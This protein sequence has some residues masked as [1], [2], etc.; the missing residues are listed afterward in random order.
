MELHERDPFSLLVKPVRRLVEERGF[1]GATGPQSRAIPLI[2]DGK[3]VLLIAPTGTGKTEAAFLPVFS[4]L[5]ELV[6]KPLGIKVLYIT[7]LRS[8]NRDLLDRLKWWCQSLD[9]R[10]SVRHGDTEAKE[11]FQQSHNP[12]DILITTPETLQAILPGRILR[13]HLSHIRWVI[14][15]EV[16]EFAEDKR[17]SQLS[18]ALER[19]RLLTEHDFQ[20][21]GLSATIGNPERVAKFL[22]G[23]DR[24]VELVKVPVVR[25]TELQ[26]IYPIATEDD[27]EL[28]ENLYT[29]PEVASRLR[30]MRNIIEGQRAVLLFTNTRSAAEVLASRFKIWDVNFPVSIHHGSLAKPAR[31]TAEQGLKGGEL[32]GLVCTSSLELGIDIGNIDLC[33]QYMSPRQV[34]RLIQRVGR[35]GHSLGR[36]AK[37]VIITIDSDDT[38]EAMVI[39]R[40]AALET[41]EPAHIP[42]KPLDALTHQIVG[43]LIFQQRWD[44]S[45]IIELCNRA[46]PYRELSEEDLISVL[47][48]MHSRYPRLGWVSFENKVVMRPQSIKEMYQFYYENL[49]MIPDEKNYI[50]IDETKDMPVGVLDEAFVAE[51]GNPGTKF[52]VRGSPWKVSNV[53]GDK[54]YV[55]PIDDPTGAIPSWI[56]EEI[57]V[58]FEVAIEVG[59]IRKLVEESLDKGETLETVGD[60][61]AS[62]YSVD[63]DTAIRA[64]DETAKQFQ[65]GLSMP[66]D[67]RVTIEKWGEFIIIHASFGSLVNRSLAT[68][69]GYLLSEKVGSAVGVQEDPYRVVIQ[70]SETVTPIAIKELLS[71]LA[72][73]D[74]NSLAA[75]SLSNTGF[76]K[77]RMIH[78]ARKFGAISKMVDFSNISLNQLTK[79]FAGTAIYVEAM[80]DVLSKDL[81]L[82]NLR[83]VLDGFLKGEIEVV[84]VTT[85]GEAT[86]I[87]QVGLE[88]IKRQTNIVSSERMKRLTIDSVRIRLLGEVRTFVCAENW[89]HVKMMS[90]KDFLQVSVCPNCGS[91]KIGILNE[92]AKTVEKMVWKKHRSLTRRDKIM[93]DRALKTGEL[94]EK[95]GAVAAI[96]LVTRHLRLSEVEELISSEDELNDQLIDRIVE[97]E[98]KALARQFW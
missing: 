60:L 7:P 40:R 72:S 28:A 34:T 89:D 21:I 51:Y 52:I 82:E 30:I 69:L 29:R 98:R 24:P 36:V 6:E 1:V 18:L 56:G 54:I 84:T 43:L 26:I 95:H 81:D 53:Y 90:V 50:V 16:H 25:E 35:S 96:A 10:V 5:L 57:P 13:R 80:K 63:R 73:S 87:A 61:L 44:F 62:R 47:N 70:T 59:Q 37:G 76:F 67:R 27:E 9:L 64:I 55:K 97:A 77:R 14:I 8:L 39:V 83:H 45:Q 17:G 46:Y 33:I 4:R 66:T 88:K 15:D 42:E 41:L 2:L 74:L 86:P 32:K 23:T 75:A 71:E 31:I 65:K 85:E 49:S 91:K 48:Y 12:P 94:M 78:V 58:P 93:E 20:I 22:A 79:S 92:E 11:R 68:L 3:N 38:L 19:L